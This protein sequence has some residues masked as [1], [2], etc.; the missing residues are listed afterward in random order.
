MTIDGKRMYPWRAEDCEG[1]V[2]DI[3]VQSRRNKKA[4]LKL[5]RKLLRKQGSQR[6]HDQNGT[7]RR[8]RIEQMHFDIHAT[9]VPQ[10][11]SA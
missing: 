11:D 1:E 4:A 8:V 10:R 7:M 5:I 6:R 2:L 3:L 9:A